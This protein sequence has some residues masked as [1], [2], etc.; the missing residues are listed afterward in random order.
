MN[1]TKLAER[2][3]KLSRIELENLVY[4][5]GLT[6]AQ[7]NKLCM[8][9][10]LSR[11]L[12]VTYL[13]E[14]LEHTVK[15]VNNNNNNNNDNNGNTNENLKVVGSSLPRS[16]ISIDIGIK[17][18]AYIHITSDYKILDWKKITLE[19]KSFE[20]EDIINQLIPLVN[21][22]FLPKS[23]IS[24]EKSGDEKISERE[25]VDLFIIERQIFR[26]FSSALITNVMTIESM[27]F[28]IL[29]ILRDNGQQFEVKSSFPTTTYQYLNQMIKKEI[30]SEYS[31][32]EIANWL[33]DL[34]KKSEIKEY[35]LGQDERKVRGRKKNFS[36]L[37]AQYWVKD[38]ANLC[39]KELTNYFN[40]SKKKDDLAD[41]L[42]Q[43]LVYLGCRRFSIHEANKWII[44]EN[45][46]FD[47]NL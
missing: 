27:L 17:N 37:I 26:R 28:T 31:G 40:N 35:L 23:N 7:R 32:D 6:I 18:L 4:R 10:H 20:P 13:Q 15:L 46:L 21:Q 33:R 19:L 24:G 29:T 43:G 30:N 41:C 1:I 47:D 12:I 38:H 14:Q 9:R 3:K 16:I 34:G 45:K 44:D 22:T 39:S 2:F 8:S 25:I 5:C 42:L 11:H 36:K